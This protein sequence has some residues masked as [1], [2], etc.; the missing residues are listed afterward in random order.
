MVISN[1]AKKKNDES[2]EKKLD[3]VI[4]AKGKFNSS[5]TS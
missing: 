1:Q 3:A 4:S 2:I 5:I